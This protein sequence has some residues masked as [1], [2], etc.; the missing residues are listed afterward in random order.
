MSYS[1]PT[2][3]F[4]LVHVANLELLLARGGLHA[5]LHAPNDGRAYR[6]IHNPDIQRQRRSRVIRCG[7]GGVIH[8]YVPFFLGPR[9]PMLLQLKTGQVSGYSG[10]QE[11][12]IYLVSTAQS[13][14]ESGAGFVFS[15]GQGIAKITS[16]FDDLRD[17]DKVD[18]VAVNATYWSDGPEDMDRQRRKQA[19]FLVHRFVRWDLISDVGVVN[20]SARAQVDAVFSAVPK[21]LRRTAS[22]R[23]EWYYL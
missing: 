23:P 2:L 14:V 8:D 15:D 1:K 13:V 19:E 10:G 5:P 11:P 6:T 3:I 21:K 20:A 17:L 22:V 9:P 18:W 7:P 16:W 4:R 12:L